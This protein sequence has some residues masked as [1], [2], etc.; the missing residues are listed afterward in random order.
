VLQQWPAELVAELLDG[1]RQRRLRHIAEPGCRA[2][3]LAVRVGS[4]S[5]RKDWIQMMVATGFAA[6]PIVILE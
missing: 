2:S 4:Q 5:E 3:R 1:A 6:S